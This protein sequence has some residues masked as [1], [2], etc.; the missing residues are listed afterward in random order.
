[1]NNTTQAP[2]FYCNKCEK[3]ITKYYVLHD[4]G[5]TYYKCKCGKEVSPIYPNE[6]ELRKLKLE[7]IG[8]MFM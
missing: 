2:L 4:I 1:M 8:K 6:K 7:K 3:Y 5:G